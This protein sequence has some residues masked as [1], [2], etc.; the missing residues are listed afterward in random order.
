LNVSESTDVNI[1]IEFILGT[2][3]SPRAQESAG[4]AAARLAAR[5]HYR[6]ETGLTADRVRS[7]WARRRDARVGAAYDAVMESL[8][9]ALK[10]IDPG[11]MEDEEALKALMVLLTSVAI[12]DEARK[13]G[14]R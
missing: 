2:G 11:W 4:E 6:L 9:V 5:A 12:W 8:R 3:C 10:G 14:G 7:L 13:E 1:L